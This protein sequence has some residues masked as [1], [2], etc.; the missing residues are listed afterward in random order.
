[1]AITVDW[2]K[3]FGEQW[4]GD[5]TKVLTPFPTVAGTEVI[6]SEEPIEEISDKMVVDEDEKMT[7]AGKK[8]KIDGNT[9]HAV[10]V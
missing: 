6:A 10:H 3:R 8:R 5:I 7:L 1:M 9:A 4:W 2:Y